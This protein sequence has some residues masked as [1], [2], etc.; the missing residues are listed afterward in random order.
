MPM[1]I[2]KAD[3]YDKVV[4][5]SWYTPEKARDELQYSDSRPSSRGPQLIDIVSLACYL[6]RKCIP[7]AA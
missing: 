6:S 3:E 1:P 7:C 5:V 4:N 2:H